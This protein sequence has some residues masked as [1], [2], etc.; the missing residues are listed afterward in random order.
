V[1]VHGKKKKEAPSLR[2]EQQSSWTGKMKFMKLGSK[3]DAFHSA[4]ADVR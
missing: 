4:G 3:P 1:V 2:S